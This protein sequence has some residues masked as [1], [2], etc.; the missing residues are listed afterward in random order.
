MLERWLEMARRGV[1]SS[2]PTTQSCI[3]AMCRSWEG[4]G[5]GLP[6]RTQLLAGS[7]AQSRGLW[8]RQNHKP[9]GQLL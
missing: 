7:P 3:S 6:S 9:A 8:N 1:L 4:A 5:G 2:G